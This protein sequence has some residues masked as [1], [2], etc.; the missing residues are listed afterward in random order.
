[1]SRKYAYTRFFAHIQ[2]IISK[3]GCKHAQGFRNDA[4]PTVNDGGM[5]EK[6]LLMNM[7]FWTL[8]QAVCQTEFLRHLFVCLFDEHPE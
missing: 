3:P 4:R 2:P 6:L 7:Y 1:M 8:C 5:C